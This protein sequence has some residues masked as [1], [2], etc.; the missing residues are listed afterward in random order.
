ML[1]SVVTY[2]ELFADRLIEILR[3]GPWAI[4][5]ASLLLFLLFQG[6][7]EADPDLFA[8]A[9]VGRL[10][11]TS[12]VAVADPF[13]FTQ[14]KSVWIDHEWLSGWIFYQIARQLGDAGLFLFKALCAA[15]S[16]A[17]LWLAASARQEKMSQERVM[18]ESV[19]CVIWLIIVAWACSYVWASTVR[20]QVFTYLALPAFL[21]AFVRFENSRKISYLFVPP[22]I[23]L[24]WA[25]A[26]GGFVVG[27]GLLFLF[28][29]SLLPSEKTTSIK[30][31]A[32][33]GL[34]VLAT[35][36]NPYGFSAYWHYIIDALGMHRST[37]PEWAPINLLSLEGVFPLGLALLILWGGWLKRGELDPSAVLMIGASAFFGFKHNRLIAIF[38]MVTFVYGSEFIF[39]ALAR[40]VT[41]SLALKLRRV[42]VV[43]AMLAGCVGFYSFVRFVFNWVDFSL[44]R[45]SYPERAITWL[46]ENR[47]G[48]KLLVDFNNGSYALFRLYPR[49]RISVDG[50]YEEVY[51]D[52]TVRLV[53]DALD[54]TSVTQL[55]SLAKVAPDYALV[56]LGS[57]AEFKKKTVP[58]W[59]E[60]YCDD[61]FCMFERGAISAPKP[62]RL[63]PEILENPWATDF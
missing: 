59:A 10:V 63:A 13:A 30:V 40:I 24:F 11:A 37:I 14:T 17:L 57:S 33:L 38:Y 8:R 16:L 27:L 2:F 61:R 4:A 54:P 56:A 31:M 52:D 44:D 1:I 42:T 18:Q 46:K 25:N 26:H 41:E 60:S 19:P 43:L 58:A 35:M 6:S 23:T 48:G 50:R 12:G 21:W 5:L 20:A 32:V 51:S 62:F 53:S 7:L 15:L 47:S 29:L 28:G 45:S 34:C 49:F 55:D 36:V 22:L 9:A 39:A 3:K